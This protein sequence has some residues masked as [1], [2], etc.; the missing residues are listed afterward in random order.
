MIYS[1]QASGPSLIPKIMRPEPAPILFRDYCPADRTWVTTANVHHYTAIEGFDVSF[2]EA[3]S[4]ALDLLEAQIKE[5]NSKFLIVVSGEVRRSVGCVFFCAEE[6]KA[7]RLRLFYLDQTYR[8]LGIGRDMIERVIAHAQIQGFDTIRASTY[9][10]HVAACRLYRTL[11]FREKIREPALAFGQQMR[12]IDFE[13][14]LF[15]HSR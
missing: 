15:Y 12:Q 13:R 10:R 11:G 7:G 9:D 2:A 3:V 14:S 6:P 1:Y 4:N 5:E 8:D